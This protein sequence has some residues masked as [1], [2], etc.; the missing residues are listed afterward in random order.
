MP[1]MSDTVRFGVSMEK[2]LVEVLDRLST[3]QGYGNR[4]QML[5]S[6]VRQEVVRS[7]AA[8]DDGEVAGV[9]TLVYRYGT[10]LRRV[11]TDDYATLRIVANTQLHLDDAVCLKVMILTGTGGEVRSWAKPLITQRGVVGKLNISATEELYR[12]LSGSA[13]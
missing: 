11:S 4:S 1:R 12:E 8:A 6:L 7:G 9:L 2:S 5:R 3:E 10:R 13:E